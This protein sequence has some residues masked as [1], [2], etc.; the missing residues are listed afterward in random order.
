MVWRS[1][2]NV[3]ENLKATVG[4]CSKEAKWELKLISVFSESLFQQR[5]RENNTHSHPT[6]KS[7][8][9]AK[10]FLTVGKGLCEVIWETYSQTAK[11]QWSNWSQQST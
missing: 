8:Q 10:N 5:K 7:P 1:E 11:L 6:N 3:K 2:K 9:C 4:I